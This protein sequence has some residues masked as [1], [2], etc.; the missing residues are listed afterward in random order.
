[1]S[2]LIEHVDLTGGMNINPI[3]LEV[4]NT[5]TTTKMLYQMQAKINNFI[6]ECNGVLGLA[7]GYTDE[8]IKKIQNAIDDIVQMINDGTIIKDG[9]I[10]FKK[11]DT[12]FIEEFND[13]IITRIYEATK[14]VF[15]GLDGDY[16]CVYKP[17]TWNDIT[18]S[19]SENGE[20]ILEY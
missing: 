12:S 3:P 15:F 8:E 16:F 5:A 18:F 20:L 19:T 1:M 4:G 9:T 6:D 7:N 17:D 11:M 14:T 2:N 13:F 10:T